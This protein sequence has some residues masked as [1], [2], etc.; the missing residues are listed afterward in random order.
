MARLIADILGGKNR[1]SSMGG[2]AE[3]MTDLSSRERAEY[4]KAMGFE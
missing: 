1:N 4:K 2:H 3:R